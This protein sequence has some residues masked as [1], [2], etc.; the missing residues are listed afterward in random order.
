M[1]DE[2]SLGTD[3]FVLLPDGSFAFKK[4][5]GSCCA[6]CCGCNLQNGCTSDASPYHICSATIS[7]LPN[8]TIKV[9]YDKPCFRCCGGNLLQKLRIYKK[10]TY[11]PA[12][13]CFATC[14]ANYYD[15]TEIWIKAENGVR[16]TRTRSE[17]TLPPSCNRVV[18]DNTQVENPYIIDWCTYP[19]DYGGIHLT[20]QQFAQSLLHPLLGDL[21]YG[22]F[23][24]DC[25]TREWKLRYLT[26]S[27]VGPL[28]LDWIQTEYLDAGNAACVSPSCKTACCL[29]DNTCREDLTAEQCRALGGFS[30]P[31]GVTCFSANCGSNTSRD[32]GACCDPD[33]G[34]C[35]LTTPEGCPAPKVFKGLGTACVLNTC[36]QPMGACCSGINQSVCGIMTQIQCQILQGNWHGPNSLCNANACPSTGGG[37]CCLPDGSCSNVNSGAACQS[38]GGI[39]QGVGS[40]CALVNCGGACCFRGQHGR[41]CAEM[42][43]NDC[44]TFPEYQWL[45][46]GATCVGV[47]CT[48]PPGGISGGGDSSKLYVPNKTIIVPP[49]GKSGGCSSCG[50][51]GL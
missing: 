32:K 23:R 36:P 4:P 3:G 46:Y 25:Y 1:A 13:G 48:I 14:L 33:T 39:F 20:A 34:N 8:Q 37:A 38:L 40:D 45:G 51:A 50:G 19:S 9:H 35:T 2:L 10:F 29:P 11:S 22:T 41:Q 26:Q 47:N 49:S 43:F 12:P 24:A 42:S 16:T 28:W 6:A 7:A 15:V 31:P 44:L 30:Q 5:D 27:T 18:S 17:V 21:Q